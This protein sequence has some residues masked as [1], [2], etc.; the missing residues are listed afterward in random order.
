MRPSRKA[1]KKMKKKVLYL[2]IA[3]L[4]C[5]SAC[6]TKENSVTE[7]SSTE[8]SVALGASL[9][10]G[11]IDFQK[12]AEAQPLAIKAA[13]EEKIY[14]ATNG[15]AKTQG[16]GDNAEEVESYRLYQVPESWQLQQV[17]GPQPTDY[18]YIA[19]EDDMTFGVQL[20]TLDAYLTSPLSGGQVMT[21]DELAQFLKGDGQNFSQETTISIKDQEWQVG[22]EEKGENNAAKITFYRLENT[23]NYDDSLIVGAVIYPLSADNPDHERAVS[24]TVSQLKTILYQ[25]AY[26]R[27]TVVEA[28]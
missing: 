9:V 1:S 3:S 18:T 13:K 4:L 19:S 23:G 14:S 11:T 5:L 15:V 25:V 7:S 10:T 17:R 20:Y 22:Y 26:T 27:P 16:L 28:P 21:K 8:A 2:G 24:A 6:A 12:L